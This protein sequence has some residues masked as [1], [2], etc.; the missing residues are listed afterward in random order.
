MNTPAPEKRRV[1]VSS[2]SLPSSKIASLAASHPFSQQLDVVFPSD[3]R[4]LEVLGGLET[5]YGKAKIRLGDVL[6]HADIFATDSGKESDPVIV[7]SNEPDE[8]DMWCIDPRGHLTI[9]VATES[10]QRLGLLGKKLPFKNQHDRHVID[11]PLQKNTQSVANQAKRKKNLENW[12]E[13]RESELGKGAGLWNVVYCANEK[14]EVTTP[15]QESKQVRVRCKIG[16][17]NYMHVPT[18]SL[19]PRP[20]GLSKRK[21]KGQTIREENDDLLE[22]WDLRVESLFEWIGMA[23]LGAQRLRVNDRVEPYVALY[24]PP[25]P[26]EMQNVTHL[27]WCGLLSP[28]FIDRVIHTISS[29]LLRGITSTSTTPFVGITCHALCSSPISYIPYTTSATGALQKPPSVP[30]KL[31]RKDGED[32]WS[33]IIE[34]SVSNAV[35]I[36]MD[37]DN[38]SDGDSAR[39]EW[40]L[41]ES[42]GQWDARWG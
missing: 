2:G 30:L 31:P 5:V 36:K 12:D 35:D 15:F 6:N 17:F 41:A 3:P 32:T 40:C 16:E 22:D 29:N 28:T 25:Q 20:E 26:S 19:R 10:Y 33:L 8:E 11:I 23:C 18:L 42:L 34:R 4:L 13:R 37:G 38:N 39:L 9:S 7:C 14:A 21:S 1:K 24:E 27:Q